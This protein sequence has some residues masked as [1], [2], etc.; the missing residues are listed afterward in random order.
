L[1]SGAPGAIGGVRVG[2]VFSVEFSPSYEDRKI[3]GYSGIDKVVLPRIRPGFRRPI[4]APWD[5]WAHKYVGISMGSM[6]LH[7]VE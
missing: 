2:S 1:Q 6:A 3:E 7:G 5:C 4:L